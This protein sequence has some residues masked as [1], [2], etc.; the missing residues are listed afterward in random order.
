MNLTR[1]PARTGVIVSFAYPPSHS[2]APSFCP[3]HPAI[4]DDQCKAALCFD[5]PIGPVAGQLWMR[6]GKVHA[7][8]PALRQ[9]E[10]EEL[11]A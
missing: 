4:V 11:E 3:N 5:D 6:D 8:K 9:E 10:D 2:S 7:V 1:T